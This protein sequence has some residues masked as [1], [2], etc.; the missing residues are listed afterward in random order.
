MSR[1]TS[2]L[3]LHL[4]KRGY[5]WGIPASILGLVIV[6]TILIT[7][8][9]SRFAAG[10]G[11]QELEWAESAQQNPGVLFSLPGFLVYLGVQAVSTTFPYGMS[12]GTT[13]RSYSLGTALY[14]AFQSAYLGLLAMV[15]YGVELATNHWFFGAPTFDV[16]ALGGG[17]VFAVGATVFTVTFLSL[18]IGGLFG[19][20]Y[21]KSG[22]RGPLIFGLALALT[23][24]IL[25]VILA[26]HMLTIAAALTRWSVLGIAVG[27]AVAAVIGEY[28][29]LRTATVR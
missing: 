10:V 16:T 25:V 17:N 26:P 27:L 22:S 5:V 1:P 7:I 29:A 18:S 21:V 3:K 11:G 9:M 28:F 8:A 4:T 23:V 15:L 14:F 13:R 20:L 6:I 19:G 12:L 24:V 2:V